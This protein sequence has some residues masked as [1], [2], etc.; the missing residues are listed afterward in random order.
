[1]APSSPPPPISSKRKSTH[2]S[3]SPNH[4]A[5]SGSESDSPPKK[6]GKRESN[7]LVE[8]SQ[9]TFG[10]EDG[11]G[12]GHLIGDGLGNGN[13]NGHAVSG[14]SRSNIP[15]PIEDEEDPEDPS[16]DVVM[17]HE[18]GV[19]GPS[20][21]YSS[22]AQVPD[23]LLDTASSQAQ[24][25]IHGTFATQ[26]TMN[27]DEDDEMDVKPVREEEGFQ[28]KS[29][30]HQDGEDGE[31]DEEEEEEWV[32]EEDGEGGI[33]RRRKHAPRKRFDRHSDG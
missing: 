14:R 3:S 9:A 20:N 23:D 25:A 22:Q 33:I 2:R 12:T 5:D 6:R 16:Q 32:E 11:R 29:Q 15:E 31:G 28:H 13:R 17:K 7:V 4:E 26:D 18:L 24:S 21:T 1:M 27:E 19:A 8:A 30:R 10:N